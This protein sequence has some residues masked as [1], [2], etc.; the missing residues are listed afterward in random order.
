MPGG[1]VTAARARVVPPS[2]PGTEA[3]TW[4][5]LARHRMPMQEPILVRMPL[6]RYRKDGMGK[7]LDLLGYLIV[8]GVFAVT[9]L[10][11]W[12]GWVVLD[13]GRRRD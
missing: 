6:V 12:L 2:Y 9:P 7:L 11:L 1:K 13:S 10:I 4:R 5:S 3:R 8:L